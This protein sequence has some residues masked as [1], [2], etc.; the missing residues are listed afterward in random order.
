MPIIIVTYINGRQRLIQAQS[1][2]QLDSE[3]APLGAIL[4]RKNDDGGRLYAI[5]SAVQEV[6]EIP[7]ATWKANVEAQERA[8][9]QKAIAAT[10]AWDALPWWKKV[11][12]KAPAV[13]VRPSKG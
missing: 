6:E 9:K 8:E 13:Q 1:W 10:A 11:G 4:L 7:D 2:R 5:K 3:S 12:K